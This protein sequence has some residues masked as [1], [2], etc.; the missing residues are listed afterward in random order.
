MNYKHGISTWTFAV[1]GEVLDKQRPCV[2]GVHLA[3][4]AMMKFGQLADQLAVVRSAA[5]LCREKKK[6]KKLAL[7][8]QS[9]VE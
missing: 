3:A 2:D 5:D 1:V 4:H 6:R 7:V 9:P 8:T